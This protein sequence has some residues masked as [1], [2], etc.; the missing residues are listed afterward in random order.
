MN[1]GSQIR[2]LHILL[3]CIKSEFNA[4]HGF[5]WR[6]RK[7]ETAYHHCTTTL[8]L[9][10]ALNHKVPLRVM[11]SS[12]HVRLVPIKR[13]GSPSRDRV[14][15]AI[16]C[17]RDSAVPTLVSPGGR[18]SSS[19]TSRNEETITDMLDFSPDILVFTSLLH[20]NPITCS[21]EPGSCHQA[22]HRH[23]E[24]DHCESFLASAS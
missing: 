2:Y 8:G 21:E 12:Q 3:T 7:S 24:E 10:M 14:E 17:R 18:F 22:L 11:R 1:K 4:R 5:E 23:L 19:P 15:L 20:S 13:R 6:D 9:R 16:L